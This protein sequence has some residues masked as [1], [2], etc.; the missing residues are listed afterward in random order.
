VSAPA[1][2]QDARTDR[3]VRMANQI[4]A[5]VPDPTRAAE[6]TAT[7]LR[8]FWAPVMI[9][10]LAEAARREPEQVSPTVRA[11]LATLTPTAGS[12]G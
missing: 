3:I 7:H 5:S 9:V 6:Q 4:A 2:P 10:D 12:H 11:A 8:T 1:A